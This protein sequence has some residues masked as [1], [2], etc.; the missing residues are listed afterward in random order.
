MGA[1]KVKIKIEWAEFHVP[2]FHGSCCKEL[3]SHVVITGLTL[4]ASELQA[5]AAFQGHYLTHKSL[6]LVL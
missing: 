1:D 5:P 6:V 4:P 2:N 3:I